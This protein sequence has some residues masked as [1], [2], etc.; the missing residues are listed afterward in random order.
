MSR[1]VDV[2]TVDAVRRRL[3]VEV[4]AEEVTAELEKAYAE[5]ARSAKV[6]GF[7]P[8]RVPRH[9]LESLF[10]DRIRAE[11]FARLIQHSYADVVQERQIDV[12]GT[13]EIVTEQAAPGGALRYSATVEVVPEIDLIEYGQLE[14]ERP[15]VPV[16]DADVDTA[17]ERL[18]Q[19]YAQSYPLSEDTPAAVG[20]VV[21]VDYEARID[22]Q[23]AGRGQGREVELGAS[24]FP[25]EFE[26]QLV[27]VRAGATL[28]FPVTYPADH[29][30]AELAGRTVQFKVSVHRV[31]RKELPP[32]DDEF[33]KDHGEYDSLGE[34]RGR[35]RERLE[36]E[37]V[38]RADEE[39]RRAIVQELAR[40]TD[41]L[42]PRALVERRTEALVEEV[43]HDW[44]QRRIRPQ[45]ETV[46]RARLRD[47]LELQAREQVKIGLLLDAIARR[48]HLHV[49]EDE[50]EA[51]IAS[52]VAQA[53][54]AGERLRAVY[55]DDTARRQ[56]R[57]RMLQAAAVDH[58]VARA[59]IKTVEQRSNIAEVGE[60]G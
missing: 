31:F 51:R 48:E 13:P 26:A 19:S 18:R 58:V 2:E 6:R 46:A 22:G 37:A 43:L 21:A 39:V 28:E 24:A 50:L 25:R 60:N 41:V 34:L 32:L 36:A 47:D 52:L 5:L 12:V 53:G 44:Q 55:Q 3:A 23:L 33:A 15:L 20:H 57:T 27:G 35:L 1:K 54:A 9:V 38:R 8:G 45:S 7:R 56:L 49:S 40:R 10:G 14:V 17:L 16:T 11:V 59:R 30:T 4:P 42:L 29:P